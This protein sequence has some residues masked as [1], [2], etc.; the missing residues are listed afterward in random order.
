PD[1]SSFAV[2]RSG[3]WKN[4]VVGWNR[5][6][7]SRCRSKYSPMVSMGGA[8]ASHSCCQCHASRGPSIARCSTARAS[9]RIANACVGRSPTTS[10]SPRERR[11]RS[12]SETSSVAPARVRTRT[13]GSS[14]SEKPSTT[15]A[16]SRV[17]ADPACRSLLLITDTLTRAHHETPTAVVP[18]AEPGDLGAA[19]VVE[20]EGELA[21]QVGGPLPPG[22]PVA[23]EGGDDAVDHARHRHAARQP[24]HAAGQ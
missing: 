13:Q 12:R 19:L 2:R 1:T 24:E 15:P 18:E 21:R 20:D 23:L 14:I 9:R 11:T 16:L 5:S 10:T 8:P 4:G 7:R 22:E 17:H 6:N 3:T